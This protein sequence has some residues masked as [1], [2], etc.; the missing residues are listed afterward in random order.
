MW[1]VVESRGEAWV[2]TR[3]RC[4]YSALYPGLF[5]L[6]LSV[7]PHLPHSPAFLHQQAEEGK[8]EGE[9]ENSAMAW[10]RSVKSLAPLPRVFPL[11]TLS[12]M[13][14]KQGLPPGSRPRVLGR[15][16]LSSPVCTEGWW[17]RPSSTNLHPSP[18]HPEGRSPRCLH[19]PHSA[20]A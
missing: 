10:N 17:L 12:T 7:L 4:A 18:L 6:S 19:Y 16:N 8:D 13:W 3:A 2:Q 20:L 5:S 9:W 15:S 11:W 1:G 14:S